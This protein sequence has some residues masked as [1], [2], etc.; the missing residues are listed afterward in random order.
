VQSGG[1]VV[2]VVDV[3]V[4]EGRVVVE[5]GVVVLDLGAAVVTELLLDGAAVD[6]VE[7][8]VPAGVVAAVDDS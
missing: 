3:V 2:V 6:A 4:V 7:P 5:A 1:N 8:V